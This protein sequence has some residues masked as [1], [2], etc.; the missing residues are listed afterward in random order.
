MVRGVYQLISI[1]CL[2]HPLAADKLAQLRERTTDVPTFRRLVYE[3]AIFLAI[4]CTQDLMTAPA[5]IETPVATTEV[6]RLSDTVTLVP[7]LRA[8]LGMVEGV[9]QW[10][11]SARVGHLGMYRNE[12]TLKPVEYYANTPKDLDQDVVI[13]LD[14]M[15]ATGG[16]ATAALTVLKRR[17]AKRLKLVSLIAAPEGIAKVNEEHPDVALYTA[18]V[19]DHLNEKGY[20]VP[21]LGDAGDRIF[22]TL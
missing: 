8:G 21:G 1:R 19:D 12:E 18:A 4:D 6:K 9:L 17:G 10:I 14:P 5:A 22:G 16:S 7:I 11:P 13:V 3:L 2:E 15:L 20:I